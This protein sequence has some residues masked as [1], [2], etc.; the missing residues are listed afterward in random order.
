MRIRGIVF[1]ILFAAAVFSAAG[2][3]LSI[4]VSVDWMLSIQ[5]GIEYRC[6]DY[7]GFKADLG[8]S[9]MGLAVADLFGV[10]HVTPPDNP[11]QLQVLLGIPAMGVP[12]TIWAPMI[13]FGGAVGVGHN[14]SDTLGLELFLGAG[15]PLF[16]EEGKEMIR[17]IHYPLNLWP[18]AGLSLRFGL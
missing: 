3:D 15:F 12:L 5:G 11:W 4:T 2:T 6:S 16:F 7:F 9:V 8:I 10:I 18:E 14:F 13:S 17:D 1:L